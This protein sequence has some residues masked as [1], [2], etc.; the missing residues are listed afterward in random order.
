MDEGVAQI[1]GFRDTVILVDKNG[2]QKPGKVPPKKKKKRQNN[3]E[4]GLLCVAR[5]RVHDTVGGLITDRVSI[6]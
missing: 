3:I 1:F 2:R 4:V 5:G 6:A